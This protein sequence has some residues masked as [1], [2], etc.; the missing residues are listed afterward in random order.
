MKTGLPALDGDDDL[1]DYYYMVM[2]PN[3]AT[4]KETRKEKKKEWPEIRER[5]AAK[6][7]EWLMDEK[8]PYT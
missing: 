3:T 4:G 8:L 7:G 1:V 6:F 2:H 5:L